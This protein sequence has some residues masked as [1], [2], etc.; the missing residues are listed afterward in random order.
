MEYT[1]YP[2]HM[3]IHAGCD[4]GSSMA[5][6]MY[7]ASLLDMK[8]IWFT[9]HDTRMGLRKYRITGFSFDESL[10]KNEDIGHH[11]F[12]LIDEKTDC[13]VDTSAKILKINSLPG[14]GDSWVNSGVYFYSTGT[15]HTCSL[16]A[17]VKLAL[18]IK[19]FKP[20]ENSRLILA[21]K[22]SQRPPDMKN[23]YVLYVLG[24]TE[25]LEGEHIQVISA[26]IKNGTL[27]MPVSNDVSD[28]MEIG[29]RDNAFDTMYIVLQTRNGASSYAEIGDF[30]IYREKNCEE[31]RKELQKVADRVGEHYGVK[32]FVSFE[33]SAAGEHKNCYST[34]VPV[35]EYHNHD[36][37]VS[38]TE[39]IEHIK[40][41]NGIFA[42]NHPFAGSQFK[43]MGDCTEPV[44]EEKLNNLFGEISDADA[45]GATL[46]EVGFPEGR[47]FPFE[48][49]L[50]LWDM[51][52]LKG[53]FLTGYGSSDCHRNNEGWFDGNNFVAYVGADA[54]LPCPRKAEIFIDAMKKGRLYTGDPVKLKGEVSFQTTDGAHMGSVLCG[55]ESVGICFSAKNVKPGWEFRIVE[56]GRAMHTQ[57]ITSENFDYIG[58]LELKG[59]DLEFCRAE[60]WDETGRCIM[61][62]NPIYLVSSFFL[63]EHKCDERIRIRIAKI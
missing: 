36:Y 23:A 25:G 13:S 47:I 60:L 4:Y 62:T 21:V 8:H 32:P 41:H 22:L 3:H 33:V 10:V 50:R 28:S 38:E 12:K 40:K 30:N 18:D 37:N 52:S 34:R 16:A 51:L 43:R 49:Y 9:D 46:M 56:S 24:S 11:G 31:L 15:R 14:E 44:R 48:Y 54:A 6:N 1:Y 5:L 2:M 7:N 20:C 61:L 55:K 19:H 39:A 29:G 27:V 63:E 42:L 26:D 17:D 57:K 58:S 59:K 35:I 53:I 45:L